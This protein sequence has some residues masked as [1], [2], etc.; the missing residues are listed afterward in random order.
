MHGNILN[1]NKVKLFNTANSDL[2]GRISILENNVYKITY[3]EII[4]GASGTL[5]VPTAATINSNEFS[6]ANCVLSE[7]DV[8]N[9]PTWVSPK[10]AGG[11]VVTATLNTGTGAWVKSGVTVSANVALIYS[12]N[13]RA[14][15]YFN[16]TNFYIID[17]VVIGDFSYV[18]N[19]TTNNSVLSSLLAS[20]M[21]DETGSGAL[22]FGTQPTFT[23]W[24]TVPRIY[25]GTGV[26]DGIDFYST[27]GNGTAGSVAHRFRGG[28]NGA[29]TILEMFNNGN[30]RIPNNRTILATDSG[31]TDR[32][33]LVWSSG[34][35]ITI[36]GRPGTTDIVLN[37]TSGGIGL[38]VKSGGDGGI[39]VA[40]PVARWH[41]IKTSEQLRVGYDTSNYFSTTVGSTGNT[42]F[43]LNAATSGASVSFSFNIPTNTGQ[44]ASTEIPNFKVNGASKT[45]LAGAITTQRWNY[46]TANTAAFAS[47]ST[48]AE[49]FGMYVEAATAGANATITNNFALGLTAG[50]ATLK[51]GHVTGDTTTAAIYLNQSTPSNTNYSIYATSSTTVLNGASTGVALWVGGSERILAYG[52]R[53]SGSASNFNFTTSNN[54]GMTASTEIPGYLYNSYS[55]QWATGAITTQRERYYK[56]VTY[57]AVG[58]S[59][60]T[61]AYGAYFEAPTASTNITI[62]NNY[63]LGVSGNAYF[64]SSVGIGT[65]ASASYGLSVLNSVNISSG[66]LTFAGGDS[67]ILG[68]RTSSIYGL[69]FLG[70]NGTSLYTS[71]KIQTTN[72]SGT[73]SGGTTSDYLFLPQAWTNQTASTE[74]NSLKYTSASTQWATGGITTQ[75]EVY[76]TSPTYSFVGAST[77]TNS[78]G[79]YVEAAT[80]GTNATITN[81]YAAGFNARI[82]SES[83]TVNVGLVLSR[84]TVSG[85]FQADS[86]AVLMG[87]GSAHNT[88]IYYNG[89]KNFTIG[90]AFTF[91]DA[92]NM[93]VGTTTGTKIG[94]ATS[95][96]LSFWNATPIVQPTTAVAAATF[97][98]NT[99]GIANDTATF[100]GYTIGQVVKALRNTGLLA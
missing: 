20:A 41:I 45:W 48:I 22:V 86:G 15:D 7:I 18:L 64:S 31:G 60:I 40:S 17:E 42:I 89:T 71:V 61:T 80:A 56:T 75:R 76:I 11:T 8:N 6:G 70:Y 55:R 29:V 81:N 50:T 30:F 83:T 87:T 67:R 74:R 52:L 73:L 96:K 49:S 99:S 24:I 35:N 97:V 100:D 84:S 82:L 19:N 94:T 38:Y 13:I 95:Q 1:K 14:A 46:F 9:K 91:T 57:T 66:T 92:I 32:S 78:Y 59:V 44:N 3:Y 77:I 47:A 90:A 58:A 51:F 34:D 85:F 98:A 2:A 72:T 79:L 4:S 5:T 63:G 25:G 62:T 33:L 68:V 39:G 65:N 88:E 36:N 28:N 23:Q 26:T 37:P 27:S 10:D 69:Q 54:T 93:A 43:S 53:T 12:L 21:S 16:L